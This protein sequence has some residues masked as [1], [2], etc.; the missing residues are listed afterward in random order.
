[1]I[2]SRSRRGV[3]T[4]W[5]EALLNSV[6]CL[7][8]CSTIDTAVTAFK[9]PL[10]PPSVFMYN[11]TRT[12]EKLSVTTPTNEARARARLP[13]LRW[14]NGSR[15]SAD[16]GGG[17]VCGVLHFESP[18]WSSRGVLNVFPSALLFSSPHLMRILKCCQPRVVLRL[19]F[20]KH[21]LPGTKY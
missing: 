14:S 8:D 21:K 13:L 6:W 11:L 16:V 12:R 18:S 9:A 10:P 15:Q 5:F 17:K 4:M 20:S 7:S 2:T 1:M 19:F 3:S